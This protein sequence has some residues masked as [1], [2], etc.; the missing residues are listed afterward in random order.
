M[1]KPRS[2]TRQEKDENTYRDDRLIIIACDD[3]YAPLQYFNMF[4]IPRVKVIVNAAKNNKSHAK[5]VVA[6][7][8]QYECE[9]DDE[10]WIV[11]DTDHCTNSGSQLKSFLQAL[12]DARQSDINI[13][14]S[15]PCFEVWLLMHFID[16][17]ALFDSLE[18]ANTVEEHLKQINGSYNKTKLDSK[19]FNFD[20]GAHACR[21]AHLRDIKVSGGDNPDRSTSRI[22]KIWQSI[23]KK[24]AKSLLHSSLTEYDLFFHQQRNQ[25][26]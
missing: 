19:Q 18:N 8:Q 26:N 4:Q 12:S 15:K 3:T 13:A 20:K 22:Y 5:Y 25:L 14:I 2:L 9:A 10:K 17:E 6:T 16:D 23:I 21:V 24:S 11:L 7:L 1:P